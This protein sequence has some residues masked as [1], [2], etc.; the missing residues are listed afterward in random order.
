MPQFFIAG[1]LVTIFYM[2][3]TEQ[4]NRVFLGALLFGAALAWTALRGD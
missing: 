1:G 4:G 2:M 3:A